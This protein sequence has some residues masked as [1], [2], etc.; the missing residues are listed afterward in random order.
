MKDDG[1]AAFFLMLTIFMILIGLS[2][3]VYGLLK[4]FGYVEPFKPLKEYRKND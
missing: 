3:P 1:A 2:I 4:Y